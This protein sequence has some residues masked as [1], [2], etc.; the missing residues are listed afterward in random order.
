MQFM[1][2]LPKT[3]YISMIIDNILIINNCSIDAPGIQPRGVV[4]EFLR[5][6]LYVLAGL[7]SVILRKTGLTG[8]H[9]VGDKY[10]GGNDECPQLIRT[11]L[12]N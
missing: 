1:P 4:G 8:V 10:R 7:P 11:Q 6:R 9:D 12:E 5:S 3:I 2:C